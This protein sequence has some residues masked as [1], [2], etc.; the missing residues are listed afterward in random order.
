MNES[1][2][3]RE[4]FTEEINKAQEKNDELVNICYIQ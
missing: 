4:E 2:Y 1:H 3:H